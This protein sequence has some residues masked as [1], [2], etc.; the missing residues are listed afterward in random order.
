MHPPSSV[1]H[2]VRRGKRALAAVR[3]GRQPGRSGAPRRVPGSKGG[4]NGARNARRAAARRAAAD[5]ID[6]LVETEGLDR[7]TAILLCSVAMDMVVTQVVDG[8]K[9]IHAMIAKNL[10]V[11]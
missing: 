6:F 11:D 10:F 7:E 3:A 1:S 8:T 5:M 4:P 2:A 9:G